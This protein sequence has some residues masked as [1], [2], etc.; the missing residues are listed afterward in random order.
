MVRKRLLD[1]KRKRKLPS[2]YSWVDHRLM[3]DRFLHTL[4]VYETALYFFLVL[5]GDQQGLSYYSDRTVCRAL[6]IEYEQMQ[7]SRLELIRKSLIA[8]GPPLYQ[9]LELPE[10]PVHL[11]TPSR[12]GSAAL[13]EVLQGLARK[14]GAQ[15]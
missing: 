8:Y 13:G 7:R 14:G 4:D 5:V 11:C 9:V 12:S 3:R 15:V 1:P 2:S 10:G 6:S